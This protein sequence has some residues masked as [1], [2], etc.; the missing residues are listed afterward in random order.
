MESEI[1]TPKKESIKIA[2]VLGGV[3]LALGALAVLGVIFANL[4]TILWTCALGIMSLVMFNI[5]RADKTQWW[6]TIPG[7][8][9]GII[10]GALVIGLSRGVFGYNAQIDLLLGGYW[11][12]AMGFPFAYFYWRDR[13]KW[14]LLLPGAFFALPAA[15]FLVAAGWAIV[16]AVMI[17]AGIYLLVKQASANKA[18]A[19]VA[20]LPATT[21]PLQ[22]ISPVK[23]FA[24]IQVPQPTSGPQ[25]DRPRP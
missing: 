5:Y 2:G 13:S 23:D 4:S 21:G 1:T 6:A 10:A 25:A 19:P 22:P 8:I 3:A 14:W 15:G 20:A 16:P 11:F 9:M 12:A 7:Y 24:P 17:V 18:P